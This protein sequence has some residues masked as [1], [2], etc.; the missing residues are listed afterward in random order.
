MASSFKCLQVDHFQLTFVL[1]LLLWYFPISQVSNF[2]CFEETRRKC[3]RKLTK[4]GLHF[5][6]VKDDSLHET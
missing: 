2:G 1:S 5:H 3:V 6:S 4:L